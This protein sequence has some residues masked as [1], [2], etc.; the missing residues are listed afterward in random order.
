VDLRR[1]QFN[2]ALKWVGLLF[3]GFLIVTQQVITNG[4]LI[5]LDAK[6]I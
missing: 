3:V 2:R 5:H 6:Y 1:Q 4:P